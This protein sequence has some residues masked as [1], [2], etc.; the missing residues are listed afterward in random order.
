MGPIRAALTALAVAGCG[1]TAPAADAA[2]DLSGAAVATM[3]PDPEIA[4]LIAGA[5][6]AKIA[7]SQQTLAAF[8]TRNTCS[9]D[10]GQSPGIG[11]ARDFIQAQYRAAGVQVALFS[12]NY[13]CP[14]QVAREDVIAWIPGTTPSRIVLIA[15]HYDSRTVDVADAISPAPGANDSG[16][17]TALLLEAARLAAGRSFDAT[18]V[19][20]SFAGEEQGLIGAKAFAAGYQSLFPGA[21]IEAVLNCDIVGGDNTANDA[22]ALAQFRL[23]S[24]GTP[25]EIMGPDGSTDDTS[26]SRGLMRAAAVWGNLYVPS[27]SAIPKLREDRPT[28][29]GDH[30]AFIARSIPGVRFIEP[31]ENLAHEHTGDDL[32]QYVTPAYTAQV[33]QL[34]LA[35]AAHLAKAPSSPN[36]L[37][38]S[39]NSSAP[40]LSWSAPAHGA[41]D[42]YV[43][44]AR[45]VSENFYHARR[46][47][48][49]T[50]ATP[51]SA[52]LDV[53]GDYYLSVAAVDAAGHESL[54]AYPEYRCDTSSCQVVP[55][56]LDV[57]LVN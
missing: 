53:T 18:L 3:A 30:E 27:L 45:P 13:G 24:P 21:T 41:V 35:A 26:P 2:T 7:A 54:F 50:A 14:D 25:R 1:E 12:F 42:H 52:D 16:S 28:R 37:V 40:S 51:T 36:A 22:A 48:N 38:V 31:T 19:F 32:F 39:G 57:T 15:G 20:A 17:Q 10:S 43:V 44:A 4:S 6:A 56:S 11:A 29:G 34:V 23:Y 5:D 49:A 55:G 47:Y 46:I 8:A 33:T 9:D